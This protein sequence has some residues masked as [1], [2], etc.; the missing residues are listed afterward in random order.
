MFIALEE[1]SLAYD[2]IWVD[3]VNKPEWYTKKVY[4]IGKVHQVPT[5]ALS[6]I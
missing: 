2:V 1:A 5:S 3:L 4:P 6:T